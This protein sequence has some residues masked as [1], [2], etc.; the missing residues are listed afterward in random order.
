MKDN[1]KTKAPGA[2]LCDRIRSSRRNAKLSQ[3]D[4]AS[5]IGVTPAAVAQWEALN[6][7]KPRI[8]RLEAIAAATRVPFDW[9]VTGGGKH[10]HNADQSTPAVALDSFAYSWDEEV[11]LERFRRLPPHARGLLR[12]LLET[13]TDRRR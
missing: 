3:A 11:L 2:R 9:L 13:L 8:D 4:L 10:N 12:E 5:L 7:T 6:G 1:R